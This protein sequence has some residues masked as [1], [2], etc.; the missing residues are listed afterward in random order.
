MARLN[1]LVGLKGAHHFWMLEEAPL[2]VTGD[3]RRRRGRGAADVEKVLAAGFI[4]RRLTGLIRAARARAAD[5]R[6]GD[7]ASALS[8]SIGDDAELISAALRAAA[9]RGLLISTAGERCDEREG[10]EQRD[11][12]NF[13][14]SAFLVLGSY[15]VKV[16][17]VSRAGE[18]CALAPCPDFI[19]LPA[20][21]CSL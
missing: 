7:A 20:G 11:E 21:F 6:D 15:R 10:G 5:G 16:E 8:L 4:H 18:W 1:A 13:H 2:G 14:R 9:G 3:D 19:W 12:R 17:L